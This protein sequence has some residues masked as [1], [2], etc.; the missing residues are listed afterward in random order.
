MPVVIDG[1]NLLYAV[2]AIEGPVSATGRSTLCATVENWARRR[3]ER[4]H[5]VFDGPAPPGVRA[6]QAASRVIQVTYSGH[7]VTADAVVST[8]LETDSA[9]RRLTVVSSDRAVMKAAKRRRARP[10]R[11]EDF[12]ALLRRD[13]SRPGRRR[14]E[15]REKEAGLGPQA[16]EQ[17]LDEFGL[18]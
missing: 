18:D 13:L 11:S 17:W 4:V 10:I 5:L 1:N 2:R 12:W 7:G 16:A 14:V 9:A 3:N 8:I 6:K 15:P